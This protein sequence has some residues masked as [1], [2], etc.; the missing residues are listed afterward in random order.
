MRNNATAGY[1]SMGLADWEI[2]PKLAEL[3]PQSHEKILRDRLT[4]DSEREQIAY[5][6]LTGW[7]DAVRVINPHLDK[8]KRLPKGCEK[9][10]PHLK[11]NNPSSMLKSQQLKRE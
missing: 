9:S 5:H 6:D 3:E 2:K 4:P 11:L 10:A 1:K 8:A 7:S